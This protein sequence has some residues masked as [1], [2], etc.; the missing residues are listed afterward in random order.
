M[1]RLVGAAGT[2]PGL[3]RSENQDSYFMDESIGLY[4]V[5]DGM[6]GA[7]SGQLAGRLTANGVGDYV[8]RYANES[9]DDGG[10]YDFFDGGLTPRANTLM[11]ALHMTN[12]LV[13]DASHKD[14]ENRGMGSTLAALL[15]D[16]DHVLVVNV[17]DSRVSRFRNGA[18]ER[19]TVDHRVSE[20][21]KFRSL[22]NPDSTVIAQMGNTLT[23]AMGV[24][25]NVKPDLYRLPL[26]PGDL[27]ILASD[28]LSDMV[29]EGTVAKILAMERSLEKK[30]ADLI[31]L[32]LAGGGRDNVTVLLAQSAEGRF[33]SL[34]KK[35][36]ME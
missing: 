22:V 6:G 27:Y 18:F 23:R 17:G 34:L 2:N 26:L 10:R 21:P 7:A 28:G 29:P 36:K 35:F 4:L 14:D 16:E 13:Y 3:K 24:R 11:Q 19:L 9:I 1:T 30:T 31:E 32:A 8:R 20:D 12:R 25:E 33:K 5:A 15:Q